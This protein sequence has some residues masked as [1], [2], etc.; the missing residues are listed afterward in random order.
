MDNRQPSGNSEVTVKYGNTL[1]LKFTVMGSYQRLM[2]A[3]LKPF[4]IS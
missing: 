3:S 1:K 4:P 2:P